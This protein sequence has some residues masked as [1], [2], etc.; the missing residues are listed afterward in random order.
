MKAS[1]RRRI[2]ARVRSAARKNKRSHGSPKALYVSVMEQTRA[3]RMGLGRKGLSHAS[4]AAAVR[5]GIHAARR[6]PRGKQNPLWDDLKIYAG[7]AKSLISSKMNAASKA[8]NE[9]VEAE[10]K[11]KQAEAAAVKVATTVATV[12][13][14]ASNPRCGKRRAYIAPGTAGARL[15]KWRWH[16]NP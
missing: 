6:N 16:H 15:A 9:A 10:R 1:Q 2:L 8:W 3:G 7:A 4:I 14:V 12:P 11:A 13:A 5:R